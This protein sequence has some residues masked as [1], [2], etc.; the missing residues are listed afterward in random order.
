M[1]LICKSESTFDL[2]GT[3][4]VEMESGAKYTVRLFE[5]ILLEA[6]YEN[7]KFMEKAGREEC[8][9]LDFV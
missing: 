5:A 3:L 4:S 8:L 2:E 6:F 7:E 1:D 9:A